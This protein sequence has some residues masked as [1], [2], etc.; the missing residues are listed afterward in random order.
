MISTTFEGPPISQKNA[1]LYQ[2]AQETIRFVREARA[3]LEQLDNVDAIDMNSNP[4]TIV[5]SSPQSFRHGHQPI[6]WR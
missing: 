6:S 4:G 1:T 3:I 5:V 2:H